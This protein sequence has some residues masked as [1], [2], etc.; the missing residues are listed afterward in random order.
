LGKIVI[1]P[2]M[3]GI[4]A[5]LQNML[6]QGRLVELVL[7]VLLASA[8][9]VIFVPISADVV[10]VFLS[11]NITLAV[12]ILL[13]TLFVSKPLDFS[14]FPSVLLATTMF[15]LVLSIATTR[16][17]LSHAHT[18]GE[19]A[20][21]HVVKNFSGFVAG[22][23]I[24]VGLIIFII[25]FVIQ[26]IVITKG[27]T[28]VSEVAARFTLDAMPGRQMAIDA[29]LNAGVIDE[30]EA[31][32]R[33]DE[34]TQSA[35]FFGAM[36]GAGKFVRGDAIA[37]IVITL[38]NI[39]A[40][41]FIGMVMHGMPLQEAAVIFTKLTIGD[42]LVT[43]VPALLISVA[44]G[45]LVT[46]SSHST[47]LPQQFVGQLLSKPIVMVLTS[48][49]VM[50]LMLTE[51][52]KIPLGMIAM[53]TIGLALVMTRKNKKLQEVATE[54]TEAAE[55]QQQAKQAEDSV[56]GHLKVEPM[57]LE[58]GINLVPLAD[59][60]K[61]GDLLDRVHRLRKEVASEIGII[62]PRV[63]I[64]DSFALD[65]TY[66]RIKI[67]GQPVAS[68][69][70]Y[71]DLFMAF[72][73]GTVTGTVEGLE[74]IDPAYGTPALWI[75]ESVKEEAQIHGYIV[76]EPNAV[77]ATHLLETVRKHA[78]E[79]LTRDA[80]QVLL[81]ELKKDSPAVVEEVTK[82]LSLAQVQQVLQL[83]LREQ[84]PIKQLG[85]I[86]EVLGDYGG[87]TKDPI[88]LT[89]F[90]RTKLARTIC[91]RY[92]DENNVLNVVMLDPA[93]EDQIRAGFEHNQNGLFPR[94]SPQALEHLCKKI[95]AEVDKLTQQNYPAIVLVNPQ[96]RAALKYMT[97]GSIPG[98]VV[99][100]QAE[101]TPDT[102]VTSFGY[103]TL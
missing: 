63:R 85:T 80:T 49:F 54:K 75:E 22:D 17:I 67:A 10:D 50:V 72:D 41:L 7:P 2:I 39:V 61:G 29:D 82:V 78:D 15:R 30:R 20:A 51:L 52:P 91:T 76:V 4:I 73:S 11:L 46:R 87:Q 44:T 93:L 36:D 3:Q 86:L 69:L 55:Q 101:I 26:F 89:T 42:G 62:L 34:I 58:L 59:P 16:L 88:I 56:E 24:V 28:R 40:G 98:L 37:G 77:I 70:V 96:I 33:R 12:I 68:W 47:N 103:V 74:T 57:E 14:I 25:I 66:Y 64:R 81:D 100:S 35:D 21:G 83:L 97:M 27:A 5:Y 8:I 6:K 95:L 9:G 1:F 99:L 48:I 71:P 32:R 45:L 43:Q 94:M 102:T 60:A 13:T 92:R 19:Y 65:P 38:V 90:V 23:N 18:D 84:I 79:I 53:S 31:K